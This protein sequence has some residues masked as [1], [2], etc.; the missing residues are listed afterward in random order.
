MSPPTI[1]T[2]S[3]PAAGAVKGS[4]WIDMGT[5]PSQPKV[6]SGTGAVAV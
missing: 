4:S 3:L 6:T 2:T 1:V 5:A